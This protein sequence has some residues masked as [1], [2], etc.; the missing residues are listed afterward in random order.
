MSVEDNK[1][2]VARFINLVT[3]TRVDEAFDLLAPDF[4]WQTYG[5]LP[6]SGRHSKKVVRT[7]FDGL[8][9]A[10][11]KPSQWIVDT[12]IGEGDTVAVE[13]HTV[14]DT[15]N[16]FKYRNFYHMACIV[17]NGLLVEIREYMDTQ[18]AEALVRSMQKSAGPA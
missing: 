18:H 14:G 4:I 6:F 9:Y 5:N 11:D 10:F 12:M 2:V 16:G 3:E 13:A 8:L 7:F 1:T 17:R 15:R